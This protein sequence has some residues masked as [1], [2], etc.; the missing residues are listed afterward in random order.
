[1][2][3]LK[4]VSKIYDMGESRVYALDD[5]SLQIEKGK[6]LSVVGKSGSGKSTLLHMIGGLD[7]PSAGQVIVNGVDITGLN[8]RRLSAF[9][10][11]NIGFVFQFFNLI[12]ELSA[13]DNVVL[14]Q[15]LSGKKFDGE[16]YEKLMDMLGI[17]DREGHLPG[18]LSGGEQQRV[19]I[20][21]ALIT[22]PELLLLD[23]PTGNLDD[24]STEA[25]MDMLCRLN[26]ELNQTVVM[27]THDAES[28]HL[29]HRTVTLRSGRFVSDVMNNG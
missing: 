2:V 8:E 21:R 17:S 16:Y 13:R 10:R 9:R 20:A 11:Q 27:V 5:V 3:T 29:A 25:V 23:E 4:N 1:M 7:E 14:A 15:Q 6:F 28:A 12:P 26:R 22:R 18:Q 24:E 19:A